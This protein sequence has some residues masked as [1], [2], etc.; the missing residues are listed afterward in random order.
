MVRRVCLS[1]G[2]AAGK[3]VGE[4]VTSEIDALDG[5]SP[6]LDSSSR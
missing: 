3:A 4:I 2:L 1:M 6:L 5:T